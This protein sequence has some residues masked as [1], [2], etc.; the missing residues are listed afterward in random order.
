MENHNK[1]TI[2]VS[3]HLS[4]EELYGLLN[5]L[6][7]TVGNNEQHPLAEVLDAV[8]DVVGELERAAERREIIDLLIKLKGRDS[9][10]M[11]VGATVPKPEN[12]DATIEAAIELF[13]EDHGWLVLEEEDGENLQFWAPPGA[14]T[15]EHMLEAINSECK[16]PTGTNI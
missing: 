3:L 16:S 1:N 11:Q 7:D 8:G 15:L 5:A 13:F 14:R 9:E 4:E 2:P 6:I 12:F 10:A